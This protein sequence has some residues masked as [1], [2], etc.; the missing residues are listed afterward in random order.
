M[1]RT[2]QMLQHVVHVTVG[3]LCSETLSRLNHLYDE[4]LI[5]NPSWFLHFHDFLKPYARAHFLL[6]RIDFPEKYS[7]M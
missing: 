4:V 2:V 7:S 5:L 1:G 6:D 3:A